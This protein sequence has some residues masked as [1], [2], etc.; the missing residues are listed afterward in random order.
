MILESARA[1]LPIEAPVGG[2][3]ALLAASAIYFA[4]IAPRAPKEGHAVGNATTYTRDMR[5]DWIK[6]YP[7]KEFAP[8]RQ[9]PLN[10]SLRWYYTEYDAAKWLVALFPWLMWL[11]FLALLY[12][13]MLAYLRREALKENLRH[14]D[15][16]P[17]RANARF[18]DRRLIGDLQPLRSLAQAHLLT[19][20]AERTAVASAAAGGL[21]TPQFKQIV[22]PTDFVALVDR[23]SAR[24]HL[25]AYNTEVLRCL[26]DAGLTIEILEFNDDPTVCHL[27]R[28]GEFIRL[29]SVVRRFSDAVLLIFAASDQ[30]VDPISNGLL[31]VASALASNR[32]VI[33]LT[34]Q[35]DGVEDGL[36]QA[37]AQRLGLTVIRTSPAEVRELPAILHSADKRAINK[38][39]LNRRRW[40]GLAAFTDFFADRPRRWM[41]PL[42][43]PSVERRRLQ[44]HLRRALKPRILGWLAAAAVYPELR[45]PLTLSFVAADG[46]G[47]RAPGAL[48]SELLAVSQLPWFRLGWM[49]DWIRSLL[50]E[51]IG[52]ADKSRV[53]RMI[54]ESIGLSRRNGGADSE[55]A[56]VSLPDRRQPRQDRLKSDAIT[57]RYLIPALRS[58]SQLFSLPESLAR[59]LA[60]KPYRRFAIIALATMP[61]AA[62]MSA[63]ALSLMPI[64]ECDLLASS[65]SDNFRIGPG[66]NNKIFLE[67]ALSRKAEKACWR[68]TT[69]EPKNGRYWYQ[70]ARV[71]EYQHQPEEAHRASEKAV[72]FG[73]PSGFHS[74]GYDYYNGVG[75]TPDLD[76]ARFY[77]QKAVDSGNTLSYGGLA[78]VAKKNMQWDKEYEY[79]V[80][81]KEAGGVQLFDL[82]NMYWRSDHPVVSES[83]AK[84]RELLEE[85]SR[86]HDWD[87]E[88][89]LAYELEE[90]DNPPD[91]RRANE[92]YLRAVQD[93]FNAGAANNL[94]WNYYKGEGADKDMA[95]AT[96]WAIFAGKLRHKGAR[97]LLHELISSQKAVFEAGYGPPKNF[98]AQEL[99][100]SEDQ[101]AAFGSSQTEHDLSLTPPHRH[102]KH[103]TSKTTA[104][105]SKAK[106]G[107]DG[108]P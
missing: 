40:A 83:Y 16:Q 66:N 36:E 35:A 43:P 91:H 63:G 89:G 90:N 49:P 48:D 86:R 5:I 80:Q 26:R 39:R 27:K 82:A 88:A 7:I 79:R 12:R 47:Q 57:L 37:L 97:E 45:W 73:Y 94:A 68:A 105:K 15:L 69:R 56:R 30:L 98:N 59:R 103:S 71:L 53:W 75:V 29:D 54:I 18:G 100:V 93:G 102:M 13:Q 8:P 22:V 32:R 76:K 58:S 23:Q 3:V 10:R 19:L 6:N 107:K 72:K 77:Y 41:Q 44:D 4:I 95:K 92:F 34:P 85:G 1:L 2:L 17:S 60:E 42:A 31:R 67:P 9:A 65:A 11:C 21:L 104:K 33:L 81:Y 84:Y 50:L 61:L 101:G 64:D 108:R 28:T 87:C 96:Y 78:D 25:A 14:L 24:D 106:A 51:S 99:L 52:D 20:D 55:E 38:L 62:A 74:M 70:L 46:Q